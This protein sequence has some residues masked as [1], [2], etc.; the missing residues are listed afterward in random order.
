MPL[1]LPGRFQPQDLCTCSS[2]CLES[3][4]PRWSHGCLTHF[5]KSLL[6]H[7]FSRA[8]FNEPSWGK[9]APVNPRHILPPMSISIIPLLPLLVLSSLH[10]PPL[11]ITYLLL[12]PS[13][14]RP[15]LGCLYCLLSLFPSEMF[16]FSTGMCS[17]RAGLC[18]IQC[19]LPGT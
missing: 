5:L 15:P 7:H 1:N 4:L 10:S 6:K 16:V 13:C 8:R 3:F 18:S 12:Y 11:E 2:I 9:M 17:I 19:S 14:P